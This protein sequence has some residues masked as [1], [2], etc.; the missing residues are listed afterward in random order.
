MAG[1]LAAPLVAA[2]VVAAVVDARRVKYSVS[3]G[4]SV[5]EE[6][7]PKAPAG[8]LSLQDEAEAAA[9]AAVAWARA[10]ARQA[11]AG[12]A[13]G[14]SVL[15]QESGLIRRAGE[16]QRR[17]SALALGIGT[18]LGCLMLLASFHWWPSR[19]AAQEEAPAPLSSPPG[20]SLPKSVLKK[21]VTEDQVRVLRSIWGESHV[22]SV[23]RDVSMRHR[24]R[25][26]AG[27][28]LRMSS[29]GFELT[30][31]DLEQLVLAISLEQS[32]VASYSRHALRDRGVTS[33]TSFYTLSTD[34]LAG[35]MTT[36]NEVI[37][38][39]KTKSDFVPHYVFLTAD[40]TA[41]TAAPPPAPE[42]AAAC[43]VEQLEEFKTRVADCLEKE[44]DRIYHGAYHAEAR[45]RR[46]SPKSRLLHERREARAVRQP[47]V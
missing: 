46:L 22:E 17:V 37:W 9:G 30:P 2:V 31:E 36:A 33:N 18:C 38:E 35:A 44:I 16:G 47:G 45:R 27:D 15:M 42:A 26:G 11:G 29:D 34:A 12:V 14:A 6:Q 32:S 43:S 3:E 25:E 19:S 41:S 23:V 10:A 8:L 40:G 21:G 1:W 13:D 5:L 7:Q 24:A 28:R 39:A 4:P 20:P